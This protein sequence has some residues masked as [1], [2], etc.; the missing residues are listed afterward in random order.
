[1][2]A[3][4]TAFARMPQKVVWRFIGERPSSLGNNTLLLKWI[5]QNDLLGY[6]KTRAFMAHWG[7]NGLYEAI[8]HG[9]PVLGLPL[10]FNQLDN[11][12]RLQARGSARVLD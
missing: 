2:D 9:V 1:M 12:V 6:P 7:T 3:I 8:Y 4:A 11:I 10:L 5:P